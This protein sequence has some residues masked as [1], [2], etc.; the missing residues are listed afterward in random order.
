MTHTQAVST[1]DY[2]KDLFE[3]CQGDLV[4]LASGPVATD[5]GPRHQDVYI[6][7]GC[8]SRIVMAYG[9]YMYC[10]RGNSLE[11]EGP[12]EPAFGW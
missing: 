8:R 9:L 2:P 10:D 7:A 1:L 5:V 6:C 11:A 3:C 12:P 4:H